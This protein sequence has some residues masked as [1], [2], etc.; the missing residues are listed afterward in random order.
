MRPSV[1]TYL[2]LLRAIDRGGHERRSLSSW[3]LTTTD[4]VAGRCGM[5]RQQATPLLWSLL[6]EGYATRCEQSDH[7]V[8]WHLGDAGVRL[9]RGEDEIV[10]RRERGMSRAPGMV[11]ATG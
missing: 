4:E 2:A 8:T 9:L 6:R 3:S 5:T 10:L 1:D 7:S 11:G